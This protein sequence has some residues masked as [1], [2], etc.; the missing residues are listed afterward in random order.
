MDEIRTN[1]DLYLF[2]TELGRK[3]AESDVTLQ[4]Y[5]TNLRELGRQRSAQS[6]LTLGE[7]ATMLESAVDAG[8]A[9]SEPPADSSEGFLMWDERISYQIQDLAEMAADGSLYDEHRYF[10]IDAPRGARWYN[11]EI[12]SYLEAATV[13]TFGGWEEG[14]ETGRGY[15]S[16]DVAVIDEDGAI[17]SADPRTLE[18]PTF[19]LAHVT[20]DS[21]TEFLVD[22]ATYE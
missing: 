13:G 19:D 1:R 10:G 7:L 14:D 22:G 9:E 11:F 6:A 21:F 3:Q 12:A 8:L 15:V 5:L 20:W 2:V 4:V 17:S 18:N 16:G